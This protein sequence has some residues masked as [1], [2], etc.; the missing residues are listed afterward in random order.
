MWQIR[1]LPSVS[2]RESAFFRSGGALSCLKFVRAREIA[3]V[4]IILLGLAGYFFS[5]SVTQ[6]TSLECRALQ[7]QRRICE[8]PLIGV[9]LNDYSRSYLA[10]HPAHEHHWCWCGSTQT[11]A[12]TSMTMACGKSHPIWR[13]PVDVQASYAKM[14]SPEV[15]QRQLAVIDSRD[16]KTGEAAAENLFEE[17]LQA[18]SQ[19]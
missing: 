19:R 3:I 14:V 2:F 4:V 5:Y 17:V 6:Y 16:R 11:Y 8:V 12:L 15:L 7:T 10:K 9:A 13:V 1:L 18:D